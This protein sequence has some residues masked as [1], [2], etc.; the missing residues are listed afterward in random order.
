MKLLRVV[1]QLKYAMQNARFLIHIHK[2]TKAN[3]CDW[4]MLGLLRFFIKFCLITCYL[5]QGK[6]FKS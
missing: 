5:F 2:A 4:I 1:L 6:N 3:N